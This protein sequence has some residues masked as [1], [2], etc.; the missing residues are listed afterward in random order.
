MSTTVGFHFPRFYTNYN[1]GKRKKGGGRCLWSAGKQCWS[2]CA[3]IGFNSRFLVKRRNKKF[4]FC[5]KNAPTPAVFA[6]TQR[7][8]CPRFGTLT[9]E[10][11]GEGISRSNSALRYKAGKVKQCNQLFPEVIVC[12][13]PGKRKP[14]HPA[15]VLSSNR[16]ALKR[17]WAVSSLSRRKAIQVSSSVHIVSPVERNQLRLWLH[18][19]KVTI[20]DCLEKVSGGKGTPCVLCCVHW[21]MTTTPLQR[22]LRISLTAWLETDNCSEWGINFHLQESW[23]FRQ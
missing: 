20:A 6:Q 17:V 12:N 11:T 2:Y 7:R 18:S 19:Q 9:F 21:P 23:S 13:K 8:H 16:V 10:K 15:S 5:S 1:S 4:F 22:I 3:V 14:I